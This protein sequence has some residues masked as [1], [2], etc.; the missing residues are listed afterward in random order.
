MFLDSKFNSS[1]ESTILLSKPLT[2]WFE[3]NQEAM[4]YF[5][6]THTGCL[7]FENSSCASDDVRILGRMANAALSYLEGNSTFTPK[8][9]AAKATQAI[10]EIY[11]SNKEILSGTAKIL[12]AIN[13]DTLEKDE[14][15]EKSTSKVLSRKN[16]IKNRRPGKGHRNH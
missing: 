9:K 4:V 12:Y 5:E 16:G 13:I 3:I 10:A 11:E 7:H 8:E 14:L 1:I 6:F 15:I 2:N